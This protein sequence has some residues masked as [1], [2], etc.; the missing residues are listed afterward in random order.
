[1]VQKDKTMSITPRHPLIPWTA[2]ILML[3]ASDAPAA[4]AQ[5]R[6]AAPAALFGASGLPISSGSPEAAVPVAREATYVPAAV[7]IADYQPLFDGDFQ[8]YDDGTF[9][10]I[11]GPVLIHGY[12]AYRRRIETPGWPIFGQWISLDAAGTLRQHGLFAL[13]E[14]GDETDIFFDQPIVCGTADMRTPCTFTGSANFEWD[15]FDGTIT[16]SFQYLGEDVETV[17]RTPAGVFRRCLVVRENDRL[18][19]DDLEVDSR[20]SKTLYLAKGCR[21]VALNDP[22]ESPL[23]TSCRIGSRGLPSPGARNASAE[24]NTLPL[25]MFPGTVRP[26]SMTF[27]NTGLLPWHPGD[28]FRLAAVGDSDPFIAGNRLFIA[29]GVTVLPGESYTFSADFAAPNAQL[30]YI[31]DWQM[32][33]DGVERFGDMLWHVTCV[34]AG[35]PANLAFTVRDSSPT[36]PLQTSPGAPIEFGAF[37]ENNGGADAGPFWFEFWGSRTGGLTLDAFLADSAVIPGI[38]SGLGYRFGWRK[39]LYNIPDGPYTIVMVADRPNAVAEGDE[40]DNRAPITGKRLVVIRPQT[41]A[42]LAIKN[43]SFGP[44]PIYNGN[45]IQLGGKVWNAGTDDSGPFWIEFWGAYN[46]DNPQLNFFLCDS[47]FVPNLP[48]G[49]TITLASYTRTLYNCPA[50]NFK[51]GIYVDRLDQVNEKNETNN[52]AFLNHTFNQSLAAEGDSDAQPIVRAAGPDLVVGMADFNPWGPTSIAPGSN[53]RLWARVEN[54]GDAPSGNFWLEFWGSKLGGLTL[55]VFLVESL[56]MPS[57][58]AGNSISLDLLRPLNSIPD[59]PYTL[60]VVADRI[61]EVAETNE[62]NNTR[63]VSGRRV[64]CVRPPT[65]ANLVVRDF[66]F[67][68]AFV[69]LHRGQTIT[70]SGYVQ[71]VGIHH[72]GPFWI[73]FWGSR[74]QDYPGLEFFLCDSIP[75][76]DLAP[77]TSVSLAAFP[78]TLYTAMP[79]GSVALILFPDRN[80]QVAETNETDNFAILRNRTIAP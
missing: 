76:A 71:N 51:A 48:A 35:A 24:S 77:G 29:P 40:R 19:I 8:I 43:F 13:D 18:V 55:D 9:Y 58:A 78:R 4:P 42:D 54:R 69:P 73:E 11:Q 60:T 5:I 75:V 45:P 50:G 10:T 62:S 17:V 47:I 6:P 1:M 64:L 80:D 52:Y 23:L 12:L 74:N 2:A 15:G 56:P 44:N 57:I 14:D 39:S 31:T 49:T 59:G 68:S 72:T 25:R 26:V 32:V 36:T 63:V 21:E 22:I 65:N 41:N 70:P 16:L 34:D 30:C 38:G 7:S 28:G 61:N 33:Q 66:A 3:V 37:L 27:R 67:G 46:R 79:L 53:L 20:V